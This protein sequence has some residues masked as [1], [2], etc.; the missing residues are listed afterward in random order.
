MS[1]ILIGSTVRVKIAN[2]GRS[3]TDSRTLLV[4]ILE[5]IDEEFYWLGSK[6]ETFNKLFTKYQLTS[7]DDKFISIV[8]VPNTTTKRRHA[9]QFS[10]QSGGLGFLRYDLEDKMY[11]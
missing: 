10:P 3:K 7:G 11:G 6:T 9:V 4:V 1:A 2:F 5:V 8:C